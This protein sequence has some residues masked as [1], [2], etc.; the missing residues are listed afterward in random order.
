MPTIDHEKLRGL[1]RVYPEREP[2]TEEH[3]VEIDLLTARYEALIEEHGEDPPDDIAAQLEEISEKIDTL[4]GDTERWIPEDMACAGCVIGIGYDGE[5]AVERGLVRPEDRAADTGS[6]IVA[7][8]R[9]AGQTN[10]VPA[11]SDRLVEDLTAHRTAA[12]RTVL[13]GNTDVALAAVVHA[14]ALHAVIFH[15]EAET[16]LEL[17]LNSAPLSG[18]AEG[19]EDSP[20]AVGLAEPHEV[21]ARQL[22]TTAEGLW[23]WLLSQ[24]TATRLDLLAYCAGYSVNTVRKR[25][26]RADSERL[27]HAGRLA[28]RDASPSIW[29]IGGSPRPRATFGM[30]RRPASSTP[31]GKA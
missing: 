25:H 4:S 17:S 21:W 9:R 26:E 14:L 16:C 12:L 31:S 8:G 2:L 3:Q 5:L 24:D 18:S 15:G 27:A 22:P 23:D 29:R 13:A 20:A 7:T 1:R 11:L 10:G 28:S 30:C 6:E 19:I